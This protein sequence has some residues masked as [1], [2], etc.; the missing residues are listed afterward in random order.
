MSTLDVPNTGLCD[1]VQVWD[2]LPCAPSPITQGDCEQLGCC[3]NSEEVI[4]CYY[5]NTGESLYFWNQLKSACNYHLLNPKEG[6]LL[7][8][9]SR[10]QIL[11]DDQRLMFKCLLRMFD[12]QWRSFL[13]SSIVYS[14][15]IQQKAN[16]I[17]WTREAKSMYRM[18]VDRNLTSFKKLANLVADCEPYFKRT[19]S[20]IMLQVFLM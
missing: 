10:R 3:Y 14:P 12:L 1:S 13:P 2:R 18:L 17:Q 20:Q 16:N 7:H 15:R 8:P 19:L 6:Y 9:P 4:S 5:G 11:K